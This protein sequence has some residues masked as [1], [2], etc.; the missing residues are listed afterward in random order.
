MQ[1]K[2]CIAD[3]AE[4]IKRCVNDSGKMSSN[5]KIWKEEGTMEGSYLSLEMRL[6]NWEFGSSIF[7]ELTSLLP[8]EFRRS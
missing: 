1:K 2:S 3:H 5:C 6:S 4:T 7:R 8:L